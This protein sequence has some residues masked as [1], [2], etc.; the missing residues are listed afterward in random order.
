MMARTTTTPVEQAGLFEV[1]FAGL[2]Y[3]VSVTLE[4]ITPLRAAEYLKHNY[5]GNRKLSQQRAR[6]Y[7]APMGRTEWLVTHEGLAFD[8]KGRLFDGQHRLT[9]CIE[10]GE[11]F[12]TFVFR[13]FPEDVYQALGRP[14]IRRIDDVATEE[15]IDARAVATGRVMLLG[16]RAGS[17]IAVAG[18]DEGALLDGLREHEKALRFVT[19]R[20]HNKIVTAPVL[21]A[22]ARAYY[23]AEAQRLDAFLR[24]LQNNEPDDSQA[25]HAAL[26]LR[27]FITDEANGSNS[28]KARADLYLR[29]ETALS[30]FLASKRVDGKLTPSTTERFP[31]PAGGE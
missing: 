27:R 26:M 1:S 23:H 15:W 8:N 3:E 13:G 14:M 24:V 22:C 2:R 4:L 12:M 9:A 21:G 18:L 25:D 16:V 5:E 19:S 29:T 30:Y 6:K 17:G 31:L 10:S 11:E 20:H 28:Y 7:A